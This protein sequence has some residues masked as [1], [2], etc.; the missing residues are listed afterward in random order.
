MKASLINKI[1]LLKNSK[2]SLEIE[3]RIKEFENLKKP[4]EIFS[5]LCFCLLTANF[6]AEKSWEIQRILYPKLLKIN[7]KDLS[8]LLKNQGHR[9][10]QQRA[11]RIILARQKNKSLIKLL[12]K[13]KDEFIL[14]D[15]LVNNITGF[16]MKE[17]SHFLRNIGY[18]NLA[19]IDFHIINVLEENK[20]LPPIKTLTKKNY[21]NI[22]KI[23]KQIATKVSLDLARLDLYLW[24]MDTGK[25]LK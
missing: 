7:E 2:V 8:L 23:L 21:L 15:W 5:E 25:I 16:G 13:E 12:N 1:N 11:K 19:I 10:W 14:R 3:K 6:K 9:F 24:Y 22:E 4:K 17:S 20:L 18:K